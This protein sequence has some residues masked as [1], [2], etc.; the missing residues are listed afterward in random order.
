MN[1]NSITKYKLNK[2]QYL[3]AISEILKLLK[4]GEKNEKELRELAT[5][6]RDVLS[7]FLEL[8]VP[9]GCFYKLSFLEHVAVFLGLAK[10][11]GP[12]T[13]IGV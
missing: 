11:K 2:Q 5:V 6:K 1:L 10:E 4:I 9:A 12:D 8:T 13:F 7:S 3:G